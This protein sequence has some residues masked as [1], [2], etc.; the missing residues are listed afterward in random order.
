MGSNA[1]TAGMNLGFVPNYAEMISSGG[2]IIPSEAQFNAEKRARQEVTKELKTL[3]GELRDTSRNVKTFG[4]GFLALSIGL[5]IIL[6]TL[7]Q[8]SSDQDIKT[9][10]V[11]NG[12]STAI[13]MIGTGAFVGAGLGRAGGIYGAAAGAVAGAGMATYQ[14]IKALDA[15]DLKN[16]QKNLQFLQDEFQASQS[17]LQKVIPLI[18]EY[19]KVQA[20]AADEQTKAF[21]LE[22]IVNEIS[23][24]LGPLGEETVNKVLEAFK[25]SDFETISLIINKRLAEESAKLSNEGVKILLEEF[26]AKGN[27]IESPTTGKVIGKSLL[28]L[29][30]SAGES[31][32]RRLAATEEGKQRIQTVSKNLEELL[33]ENQKLQQE[34]KIR[35]GSISPFVEGAGFAGVAVPN[36]ERVP[37][38]KVQEKIRTNLNQILTVIEPLY[39]DAEETRAK[40]AEWKIASGSTALNQESSSALIEQI[41]KDLRSQ[42]II[43]EKIN[44]SLKTSGITSI[45]EY[46][47]AFK[48]NTLTLRKA[49]DF[50]KKRLF[51]QLQDPMLTLGKEQAALIQNIGEDILTPSRRSKVYDEI[52]KE[53]EKLREM[54]AQEVVRRDKLNVQLENKEITEEQYQKDIEKTIITEDQYRKRLEALREKILLDQRKSGRI[55]AEDFRGGRQ[56]SRE[57]RILGQEAQLEDFG[58]AFFD[59]FDYRTEDSFRE[60]QLGAKEAARTIKSEFNNAFFDFAQGTATAGQAFEKFALNISNKIQQLALEFGTNLLFGKLFGSTSNILGLGGDSGGGGFGSLFGFKKGG[61]VK[62][63]SSG[64]TVTGGS[65]TKDDVPA[66]LSAGE[67]VIRKSSVNKY[68][69]GF[70]GMLN[71]GRVGKYQYGG[72]GSFNKANYF[73]YSGPAGYPTGGQYMIDPMLNLSALLN[74]NNPQNRIRDQRAETLSAYLQYVEGV[75]TRNMEALAENQR[76]NQEIQNQYNNQQ[77]SL[78]AYASFGL[79][80]AGAGLG[81]L[82][83][84][85]HIKGFAKGG[86]SADNIPAMLMDGEFV[87][88]K[89][90]VNLYGKKFFDNLNGGRISKFANGGAVGNS[91]DIGVSTSNYNPTNNVNVTVNLNQQIEKTSESN[92]SNGERPQDEETRR[93]KQLAEQIKIQVIR[94]ITE[95]QRPGGLLGSNIYK[96]QG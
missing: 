37:T 92:T 9:Q 66:M 18:E 2:I 24:G 49:D 53:T 26:K 88:R 84:G 61:I 10:A 80:L 15:E 93:N 19:K 4:S 62:G 44:D 48:E 85:G 45:E 23:T 8:F 72:E 76:I 41:V 74:E 28:S 11:I 5:P 64:G 47:Q 13:S 34:A 79:G 43:T 54:L 40:F 14:V 33:K 94:V 38:I 12:I 30:T 52:D 20:S 57:A 16:L 50:V 42:G 71:G 90:A 36:I 83:N 73:Q 70:L 25:K 75:N 87:M 91:N 31:V 46:I 7:S 39:K 3:K 29:Q 95:Q 69:A 6:Q 51:A 21:N 58:S 86:Q 65:G 35:T 68:G 67:Y 56:E 63:Y 22:K 59:E 32:I 96:K 82:K 17:S 77:N 27:I 89:E 78:G 1:K 55:F 60:A 81:F